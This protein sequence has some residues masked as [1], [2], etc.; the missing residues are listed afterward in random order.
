MAVTDAV[1]AATAAEPGSAASC[2]ITPLTVLR[3]EVMRGTRARVERGRGLNAAV[4][5]VEGWDYG[6]HDRVVVRV[7]LALTRRL[8]VRR[9]EGRAAG[10]KLPLRKGGLCS[11]LAP[12]TRRRGRGPRRGRVGNSQVRVGHGHDSTLVA[13]AVV[14]HC[15]GRRRG[16]VHGRLGL[17]Q[18]REEEDGSWL[19]IPPSVRR[20]LSIPCS[21]APNPE[22]EA[23]ARSLLTSVVARGLA[24][25]RLAVARVLHAG[26]DLAGASAACDGTRR[27]RSSGVRWREHEGPGRAP[28]STC[29]STH[30]PQRA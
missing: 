12:T 27:A 29:A 10:A 20:P 11:E 23:H 21:P 13:D 22:C 19:W 24:P 16:R 7:P 26:F 1:A 4:N 9:R 2:F 25:K 28:P 15:G 14:I 18:R 6:I 30:G 17:L 8:R 5:G 3:C